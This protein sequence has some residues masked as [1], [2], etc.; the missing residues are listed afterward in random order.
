[1]RIDQA[2]ERYEAGEVAD[3]STAAAENYYAAAALAF[4]A[5]DRYHALSLGARAYLIREEILERDFASSD[6]SN[7]TIGEETG[8][9]AI[10]AY[11]NGDITT[12]EAG[13]EEA[14]LRFML[15]INE[16]WSSYAGGLKNS[17]DAERRKALNA[18]ANVAVKQEFDNAD[19]F[20][21]KGVA[22]YNAKDYTGSSEYFDQSIPLFISSTKNA[23]K[24]RVIAADAIQ[25]AETKVNQSD[26]AARDAEIVLQGGA[27]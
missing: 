9:D 24:K 6:Q 12:A 16:G 21:S 18:K 27:K 11:D 4:E 1:M 19:G 10:A 14:F 17:A 13:A 2:L 5:R 26:A 15:V 8:I 25:T 3:T 23:E 7:Y 20:Y 22:A